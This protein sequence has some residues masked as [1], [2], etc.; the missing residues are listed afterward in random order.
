MKLYDVYDYEREEQFLV[1]ANTK[2]EALQKFDYETDT[3]SANIEAYEVEFENDVAR[4][5]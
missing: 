4:L 1:Y 2:E 3:F 5:S